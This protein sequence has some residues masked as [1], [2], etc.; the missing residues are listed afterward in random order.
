L[1]GLSQP[2][3]TGALNIINKEEGWAVPSQPGTSDRLNVIDKEGGWAAP[4]QPGA[5]YLIPWLNI[6]KV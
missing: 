4:S 2:G 1:G 5:I 3:A 6:I